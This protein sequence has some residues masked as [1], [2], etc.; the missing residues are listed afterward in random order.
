M[1]KRSIDSFFQASSSKKAK[2]ENET[3]T[4]YSRHATYPIPLPSSLPFPLTTSSE[5]KVV[6]DKSKLDMLY[7]RPFFNASLATQLF[8]FLRAEFCWYR[9]T[10]EVRGITINTPRFTTVFGLDDT[11]YFSEPDKSRVLEKET[12]ERPKK[13]LNC[14]PRPLPGCLDQLRRAIESETGESFN[15]CLLNYYKDGTDSISYHS[16]DE[17]FLGPDPSIASLSLGSSRD[18]H[19][20]LKSDHSVTFRTSLRSGELLL[21]RGP[22]QSA[23]DHS[24][25]K[26]KGADSGS[27]RLGRINV[28]FR[29]AMVR[30]GT[31]NYYR[32]NVHTGPFYTWDPNRQEMVLGPRL[33]RKKAAVLVANGGERQQH[34]TQALVGQDR[35]ITLGKEDSIDVVAEMN[36][37]DEAVER[38]AALSGVANK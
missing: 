8:D 3:S 33:D 29:K 1:A 17:S 12:K 27:G 34:D 19:M 30:Y 2:P 13:P 36:A 25:P 20:R 31:E 21:M 24:I 15:F 18:F 14:Q 37:I 28:T 22:T 10:Y 6:N 16:D 26:R 5:H 4:E 11:H 35:G 38:A 9:V 23:W 7:Y 32:Y